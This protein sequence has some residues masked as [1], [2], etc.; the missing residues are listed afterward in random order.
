MGPRRAGLLRA[1]DAHRS[2][3]RRCCEHIA[4]YSQR[5][6]D[7]D[8][9]T[10]IVTSIR[11]FRAGRDGNRLSRR[12]IAGRERTCFGGSIASSA[13]PK[14]ANGSSFPSLGLKP[15]GPLNPFIKPEAQNCVPT[16]TGITFD[17]VLEQV[18]PI[19]LSWAPNGLF[20]AR[21]R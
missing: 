18:H 16:A 4:L 10:V 6:S 17:A 13:A 21:R 2:T 15:A 20:S 5:I 7:S 19:S 11:S 3:C 14:S 9:H 1:R 8:D 12:T